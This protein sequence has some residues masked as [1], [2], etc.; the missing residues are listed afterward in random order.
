MAR[1][2]LS[3]TDRHCASKI[4]SSSAVVLNNHEVRLARL[5]VTPAACRRWCWR[6]SG[7]C[8]TSLSTIIP[9]RKLTSAQLRSRTIEHRAAPGLDDIELVTDTQEP[10][11]RLRQPPPAGEDPQPQSPERRILRALAQADAA[12]SQRQIRQHAATRHQ[13]VGAVLHKF[14][15]EGCVRHDAEGRYSLVARH[16]EQVAPHAYSGSRF[17]PFA[18]RGSRRNRPQ[19]IVRRPPPE[20]RPRGRSEPQPPRRSLTRR[21]S[22]DSPP[23][24]HRNDPPIREIYAPVARNNPGNPR[25][26]YVRDNRRGP[27]CRNIP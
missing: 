17:P 8:Q 3:R 27:K 19:P 25:S 22:T 7:R 9:A 23:E 6:W 16:S 14:V 1:T 12:L 10:F 20:Q 11:L 5:S 2:A 24:R 21:R 18:P 13:T 4:G 15:R 26:N